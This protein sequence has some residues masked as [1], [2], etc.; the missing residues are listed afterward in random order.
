[1]KRLAIILWILLLLAVAFLVVGLFLFFDFEER[2]AYERP[3]PTEPAAE[4]P[5]ATS[6]QTA[7]YEVRYDVSWSEA[8]HPDTLPSGAHV[9]PI[10]V[11]AHAAETDLFVAGQAATDGIE[12]MAETGATQV[13]LDEI[14]AD[15]LMLNSAV[16]VRLDAPGSTVLQLAFDQGHPRLS[17]VSMLAPSPDWF[18]AVDQIALFENGAWLEEIELVMRPYDAG[19]DSGSD[20]TSADSDTDPPGAIAPPVDQAFI[21]AAAEGSFATLTLIRQD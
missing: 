1:M 15:N 20:F 13:L 12:M 18:V 3:S 2:Q 17:A 8:T 4:V 16:G 19:T 7:V 9:S 21:G 10:V 5:A 11:V 14:N 6:A